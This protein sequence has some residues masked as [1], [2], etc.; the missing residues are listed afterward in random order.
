MLTYSAYEGDYRVRR[1]A[2]SLAR[3]GD[4][5]EVLSVS[6]G[7]NS[8]RDTMLEGV[9]VTHLLGKTKLGKSTIAYVF[10]VSCFALAAFC[11]IT[12]RTLSRRYDIVHIHNMPDALVFS[13][14]FAK[15][16][17]ARLILDLHDLV[18]E[19]FIDKRSGW[20]MKPLGWL[21]RWEEKL[22][23]FFVHHVIV[24]NHL[25]LE[26]IEAR[27]A[28][29]GKCSVFVN[30]VDERVFY[31]RSRTRSDDRIIILFHGSLSPHQGVDLVVRAMPAVLGRVPQAEFHIYG[32]GSEKDRLLSLAS[33]LGVRHAVKLHK[34]VQLTEIPQIVAEADVGVVAKRADS[35]GNL[36]YSTKILEF[37]SQ[38]LP[39]VL[40]RT[41][42]DQYYF[43]DTVARF[44]NSGDVPDLAEALIAVIEDP[45]LKQRLKRNSA[46]H[47]QRN[48]WLTR[49]QAY[50]ALVDT[51]IVGLAALPLL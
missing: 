9:K 48:S 47:V 13:A 2:E 42:I 8:P 49:Q 12:R 50:H 46:I 33:E 11:V 29:K 10:Q 5:V 21:L 3:R 20:T 34:P 16:R 18:P 19:L 39:V 31:P 38:G 51:L 6:L 28:P 17:G 44:F 41:K 32:D 7:K 40:S 27:S 15:L 24:S 36:A 26:T 37:M 23:A 14:F 43:D 35:F 1:Y 22:S 4:E 45:D 25:W 30:N